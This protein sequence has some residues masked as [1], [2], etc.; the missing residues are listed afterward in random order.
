MTLIGRNGP[1]RF[2]L[3]SIVASGHCCRTARCG[4]WS[5]WGGCSPASTWSCTNR[6]P[7]L[8][9]RF[10]TLR[11]RAFGSSPSRRRSSR[12]QEWNAPSVTPRSLQNAFAVWPLSFHDEI[13]SRHF[14]S[15]FGSRLP[16]FGSLHW[17]SGNHRASRPRRE[18]VVRRTVTRG[19]KLDFHALRHT[20]ITNIANS[21]ASVKTQQEL[22]RH[23][24]PSMTIGRYS[25][26]DDAQKMA[27][28]ESLPEVGPVEAV[29][30]ATGTDSDCP[31][32]CPDSGGQRRPA[33][34]RA[35]TDERPEAERGA[36]D[37]APLVVGEQGFI[38]DQDGGPYH[39]DPRPPV[40]QLDRAAVY[41]T[42]GWRFESSRA[43]SHK[44]C[45]TLD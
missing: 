28:I 40:A 8:F 6:L 23:A 16:I 30:K 37:S 4:S 9:D 17:G 42:A 12:R 11:G 39:D 24:D 5:M 13:V 25:H 21:G 32:Y 14:A 31:S 26:S 29:S 20:F 2:I 44:S 10:G 19:R 22:A 36:R 15:R 45:R 3:G 27:A 41:G 43:D 1:P 34:T 18:D 7:A 38:D 35:P 33:A